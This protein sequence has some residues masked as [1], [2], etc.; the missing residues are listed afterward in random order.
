MPEMVR[1][2]LRLPPELYE[3]LQTLAAQER[4][5]I[6]GEIIHIL[7]RYVAGVANHAAGGMSRESERGKLMAAA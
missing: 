5:S 1:F 7:D 6:N 4:R 3:A 2:A